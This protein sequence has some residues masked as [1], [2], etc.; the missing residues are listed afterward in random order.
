M[1]LV[2]F[3][4]S[5]WNNANRPILISV[6]KAQVQV[7]HASP[8]KLY[9]LK[10]VEEKVGKSLEYMGTGEMFLNRKPMAYTI[11]SRIDKWDLIKLQITIRQRTLSIG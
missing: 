8:I 2:Q 7:D 6:Y 11:R 4:I 3:I 1:V 10:L 9:A 5:M